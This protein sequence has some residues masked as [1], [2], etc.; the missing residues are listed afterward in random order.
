MGGEEVK[1]SGTPHII[2]DVDFEWAGSAFT[3]T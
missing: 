3:M 1:V 2:S